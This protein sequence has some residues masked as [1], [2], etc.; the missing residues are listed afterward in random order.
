MLTYYKLTGDS[1]NKSLSANIATPKFN[2][3]EMGSH[4]CCRLCSKLTERNGL[5][6]RAKS[7]SSIYRIE[8]K[9]VERRR[10]KWHVVGA[11]MK[12]IMANVKYMVSMWW[13]GVTK[14]VSSQWW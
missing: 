2:M 7:W 1:C 6:A 10:I 11:G 14:E 3:Q 13:R 8:N 5:V 9:G 4:H 12:F